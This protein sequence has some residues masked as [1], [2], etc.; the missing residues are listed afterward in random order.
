[1][2]NAGV[3]VESIVDRS[4]SGPGFFI[5]AACRS[6]RNDT[7]G[8]GQFVCGP[9]REL[10]QQQLLREQSIRVSFPMPG[11]CHPPHSRPTPS[12]KT[13]NDNADG[14]APGEDRG[15]TGQVCLLFCNSGNAG[16]ADPEAGTQGYFTSR[17]CCF[18]CA[19]DF[20][21]K[22]LNTVEKCACALK[23][24]DKATSTRGI[25]VSVITIFA[26]STRLSSRYS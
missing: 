14:A 12:K 3:A 15:E 18:H 4:Q 19:G 16:P 2:L 17:N 6:K 23:P 13:G 24:T 26:C 11:S 20:P 1:M 9:V 22:R 25:V 8:R 5:S 7:D 21:V 10:S